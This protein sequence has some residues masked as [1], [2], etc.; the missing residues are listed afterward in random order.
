MTRIYCINC[1]F[2]FDT[3]IPTCGNCCN[4]CPYNPLYGN[5]ESD[6][7]E[8]C[9][10]NN[11]NNTL[12]Q[13]TTTMDSTETTPTSTTT[14][15]VQPHINVPHE[16]TT[17]TSWRGKQTLHNTIYVTHHNNATRFLH[18]YSAQTWVM[19]ITPS[20]YC[21]ETEEAYKTPVTFTNVNGLTS[22]PQQSTVFNYPN[23]GS[24]A[25]TECLR[26]Y[27]N[28]Q[29]PSWIQTQLRDLSEPQS[30]QSSCGKRQKTKH[31]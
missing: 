29:S 20:L 28:F 16:T 5:E 26:H 9:P 31:H 4:T 1:D 30:T 15:T 23:V 27:E 17:S 13:P 3:E 14:H 2:P 10:S 21:N 19:S 24:P 11:D 8:D 6:H 22:T 7:D 18:F 12:S 25:H